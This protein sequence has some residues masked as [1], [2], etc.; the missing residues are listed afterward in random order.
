SSF[1]IDMQQAVTELRGAKLIRG[2]GPHARRAIETY[3]DRVREAV[4]A[5]MGPDQLEL[6]H[7]RLAS[8]FEATGEADLEAIVEHLIGAGDGKRAQIYAIRAATQAA[9]ALAFEK[10]A[11]LFAIAVEHQDDEGWG[12]ELSVRWADALVNAGYGRAAASVYYDAARAASE[13]EAS[14][15]RRQAGLQ[16]LSSGHEAEAVELLHGTLEELGP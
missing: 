3:H 1:G 16:L 9:E 13:P 8:T 4:V 5:A 11:R 10:A 6:W 2:V 12:H 7:K 15:L 14:A